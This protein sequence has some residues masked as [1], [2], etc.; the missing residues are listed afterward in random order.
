MNMLNRDCLND[1]Q[2]EQLEKL[3]NAPVTL[4]QIG[5]GQFLR[6]FVDWMLHGC[7]EQGL[8]EGGVA[9]VQPRPSGAS[10]IATLTKQDG[11]HTLVIRGLENGSPIERREIVS[12]FSRV[13]DPYAEWPRL[14]E[15]AVSPDLRF[16][17]S[18]TTEA[19]LAYAP[20]PLQEGPIAS[21]PGKIAY[22]LY[23][24]YEAF[25]GDPDK[26]LTFLPCE[27]VERN[28]DTLRDAVL[29]YADDW[30]L[31]QPFRE[32]VISHNRFLNSLVD[33]IVTGYPS[34]EQ[35]EAWFSEWGYRDAML[36]TAEPYHLW[37]IEAKP[38]MDEQLP[39]RTAGF[40]VIW[41]NDLRL[42][43]Q[44]KVR[45]LNGAHTWMAPLGL[46]RG[47]EHVRALMEHPELGAMVRATV[48]EDIVPTLPYDAA[49]MREYAHSVFERFAN[50]FIR[51]R[52]SDIAMNSLS[53]FKVRLLPTFACYT[54]RGGHFPEKL[55]IG[56]AGLLRY[57]KVNRV[58]D[59][60]Y[61]G[62]TF[63]GERYVVRD[64]ASALAIVSR[65]WEE[66]ERNGSTVVQAVS[67]LLAEQSLW[68]TDLSLWSGLAEQ[69]AAILTSWEEDGK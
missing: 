44:R 22:L 31:P 61:M 66:A 65:I 59:G 12:V 38:E 51:H 17:V 40:N 25:H 42:Y 24:R 55:A 8:F 15:L 43:Q 20:E 13:F 45:I 26:G 28:G 14:I 52:L 6:G 62:Q 64:D 46:L 29:L 32:W 35:A 23:S 1:E 37:A 67:G 27:L 36:N 53:K 58:E 47:V 19:G 54:E 7:R 16:V 69:V 9:V 34:V 49:E 63:D 68:G 30:G 10:K 60:S 56:L 50:P 39:F 2:K 21:F 5:E 33:R 3:K 48:L 11:L 41:T 57:Y 18:N 4:L